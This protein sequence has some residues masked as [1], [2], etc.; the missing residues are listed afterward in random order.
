MLQI[1]TKVRDGAWLTPERQRAYSVMLIVGAILYLGGLI[2]SAR[3][4]TS[5]VQHQLGADFAQVWVAGKE[6]LEGT[7]EAAF[8]LKKHVARQHL[9]FGPQAAEFGWLYPP[10]F[11]AVATL[12]APLPY[13]A[14]LA[15]WEGTTLAA[16]LAMM[17]W[18]ARAQRLDV[19]ATLLGA[20]AFPAVMLNL[21]NGQNGFLT[22]TLLGAGFLAT[23]RKPIA[24]GLFFALLA[25]KPQFA[26]V[27]PLALILDR[28]WRTLAAAG[29][30]LALLTALS[31]AAFGV[32]SWRAFFESLAVT[33]VVIE[34]GGPGF[35][36]IQSA[37]A[38]VRLLGG[39]ASLGYAAQTAIT[40]ATLGGLAWLWL[41]KADRRAKIAATLVATQLTTPYCLDYDMMALAPALALLVSLGEEKGYAPFEK[42]VLAAAFAAPL[43]A[44]PVATA[45]GLP[46]GFLCVA[47]LFCMVLRRGLPTEDLRLQ[48][49][50]RA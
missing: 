11:L 4:V 50:L 24:A 39:A 49:A 34:Q 47:L 15:L 20:L 37:F 3:F 31:V 36:K 32:S 12:L 40:L 9:E 41:S 7:P 44:R 35:D 16:Y 38:A 45:I 33:R 46:L 5:P 17:I 29:A 1:L 10:Y 2:V 27:L 42:T 22:A 14:A 43:L 26:L 13:H 48:S 8:D 25:Y 30:A 21:G 28:R 23:E 19:G 6:A 18:L